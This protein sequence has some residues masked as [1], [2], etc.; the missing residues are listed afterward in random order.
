MNNVN[1]LVASFQTIEVPS[2][3][4][5]LS[6]QK[7]VIKELKKLGVKL[8]NVNVKAI[9]PTRSCVKK[10][11]RYIE[12]STNSDENYS[13]NVKK[14]KK[15]P[16][17]KKFTIGTKREHY[18]Y[19][20]SK[21][22]QNQIIRTKQERKQIINDF[23][24]YGAFRKFLGAARFRKALTKYKKQTPPPFRKSKKKPTPVKLTPVT[25]N[26]NNNKTYNKN[27]SLTNLFK[28]I[29]I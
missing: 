15:P 14:V 1:K 12:N 28:T 17:V 10:P 11:K 27:T 8:E 4:G 18:N 7:K 25:I 24:K 5:T 21:L 9:R 3:A 13:L 23:R 26:Q 20:L 16:Q 19:I 22:R 2:K 6:K 29:K